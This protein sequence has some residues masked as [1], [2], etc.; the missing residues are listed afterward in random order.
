[1]AVDATLYVNGGAEFRRL[2]QGKGERGNHHGS[3]PWRSSI[4]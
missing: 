2:Q 3:I 1:M 4:R